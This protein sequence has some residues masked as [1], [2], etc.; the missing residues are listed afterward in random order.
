MAILLAVIAA[1]TAAQRG[2]I[3]E[4]TQII[5]DGQRRASSFKKTLD[6]ALARDNVRAGQ[7]RENQ[8]NNDAR[9]LSSQMDK[10]GDSWNRDHDMNKTRVHVRNALAL[11]TDISKAMR[12]WNMGGDA[13]SQWAAL[14]TELNRLAQT[15]GLPRIP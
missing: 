2:R 12:N 14:H 11:G 8:L 4:T 3:D 7:E 15:F 6:H 13:E 1:P 10:V 9:N 5:N